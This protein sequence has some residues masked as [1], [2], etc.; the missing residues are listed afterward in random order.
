LLNRKGKQTKT[1]VLWK[2][3][4][5]NKTEISAASLLPEIKK[6]EVKSEE[7]LLQNH[8]C[9]QPL[10]YELVAW[11]L[12]QVVKICFLIFDYYHSPENGDTCEEP[13]QQLQFGQ[14]ANRRKI[15][16][17]KVKQHVD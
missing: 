12:Q 3:T 17:Q 4:K 8:L 15:N 11:N 14:Y 9:F 1:L 7:L 5:R 16:V 13:D 6:K 10:T 2:K